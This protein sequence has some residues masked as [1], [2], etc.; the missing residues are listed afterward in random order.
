MR[1]GFGDKID[2]I[3]LPVRVMQSWMDCDL[4]RAPAGSW[5]WTSG[6]TSPP[7]L[8]GHHLRRHLLLPPLRD[9]YDSAAGRYTVTVPFDAEA[10]FVFPGGETRTLTAGTWTL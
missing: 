4:L 10:E 7:G 3:G 5:C 9:A 1:Y 6:R 8:H 2:R